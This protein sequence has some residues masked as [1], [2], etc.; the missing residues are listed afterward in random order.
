MPQQKAQ[1]R[2]TP[3][4]S[5]ER[6]KLVE[7]VLA[8]PSFSKSP[9][10]SSFLAYICSRALSGKVADLNERQI[11]IDVFERTP[12]YNP[13]DDSI[14]RSHARLL[15]IRL[16][17][18]FAGPGKDTEWVIT[19]PKGSYIPAFLPRSEG[20]VKPAEPEAIVVR[21]VVRPIREVPVE[22]STNRFFVLNV[23][24]LLFFSVVAIIAFRLSAR[25]Q[26]A[27][28]PPGDQLW[29]SL[30][31]SSRRTL[32]VPADSTLSFL[33]TG[34]KT[35]F[36]LSE[37]LNRSF[38]S[39]KRDAPADALTS[40]AIARFN[41]HQYTSIADLN[42]AFKVARLPEAQ[43]SHLEVRYARDLTLSD[44]KDSNLILLGGMRANPWVELFAD[45][46][47]F[48]VDND[49]TNGGDYVAVRSPRAG[50]RDRYSSDTKDH[51]RYGFG[52]VAYVAGLGGVGDALLIEGT[53]MAGTEGAC[54]FLFDSSAF[55][56]FTKKVTRPDGRLGHFEVLIET[57]I[58]NGDASEPQVLA[59]RILP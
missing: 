8:S 38:E 51:E 18:H 7:Q 17:Q 58:L 12:S 54:D 56:S 16:D 11:G 14:V 46:L 48:Y 5:D 9:R 36:S 47:D 25:S 34:R 15:R 26:S 31:V 10:L 45:R 55:S 50:E 44:V 33:Q 6:W 21:E 39:E 23:S 20:A 1:Y 27:A 2:L 40:T 41:D 57:R 24:A 53:R 37:Y 4:P 32:L 42:M 19:I 3:D 35:P 13:A 43:K 49:T 59:Y 30:L 22:K 28:A 29:T 52:I